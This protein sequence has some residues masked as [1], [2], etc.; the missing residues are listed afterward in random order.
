MHDPREI[1]NGLSEAERP[2]WADCP[3]FNNVWCHAPW[4][5]HQPCPGLA[6]RAILEEQNNGEHHAD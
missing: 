4:T 1:A 3:V 2:V 6:V 5:C